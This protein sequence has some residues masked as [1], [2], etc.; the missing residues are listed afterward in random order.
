MT[1]ALSSSCTPTRRCWVIAT[2]LLAGCETPLPFPDAGSDATST[3]DATQL[4][5]GVDA[6]ARD[7]PPFVVAPHEP[8]LQVDNQGGRTLPHPAVVTITYEGDVRRAALE[9]FASWIVGSDWLTAVGAEYGIGA[10]TAAGSAVLPGPA[11]ADISDAEIQQLLANGVVDGSIPTPP[12]GLENALFM[13]YFPAETTVHLDSVGTCGE[14]PS[15][16]LSCVVFD[17]YHGEAHTRG[18]DFAYAV[19]PDCPPARPASR[20]EYTQITASHELIEAATDPFPVTD[21]AW[22]TYPSETDPWTFAIGCGIEVADLCTTPLQFVREDGHVA[23]RSWSN[24]AAAAGGDPCVPIDPDRPY[25]GVSASPAT[26]QHV[27]PGE[28]VEFRLSGWSEVPGRDWVLSA[29][30]LN[31]TLAVTTSLSTM[32]MNNGGTATLRVTVPADAT[33]GTH[34]ALGIIS[35]RSPSDFRIWAVDVATP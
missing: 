28:S 10:G 9:S 27:A 24:R 2:L 23:Q 12:S 6:F 33:P 17:A 31:G 8:F 19:M 22:Q 34:A 18:L 30:P 4:D 26:V 35:Q 29:T 13:I 16:I 1:L 5:T 32:L 15:E 25:Y 21:R 14:P 3:P 7:A 20:L 11:P